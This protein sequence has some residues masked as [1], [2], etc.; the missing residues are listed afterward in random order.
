M[1]KN[2][3]A[4]IAAVVLGALASL[5]VL[6]GAC[7]DDPAIVSC[8]NIPAG[9]CPR[10]GNACIDPTCDVLYV[11]TADGTWRRDRT[12]PP[13]DDAGVVAPDDADASDAAAIRDVEIDVPG[14]SGGPGCAN[15][16]S[17]DCPLATAAACP[18]GSCCGC[19]DLFVCRNGGWETWGTCGPDGV[20]TP[21]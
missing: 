12:C 16:E 14:S 20:I 7:A 9:G 19:E 18:N 2:L 11:C 21:R 6:V 17:P 1:K 4:A 10:I 5:A 13:H 15:L 3:G 8:K